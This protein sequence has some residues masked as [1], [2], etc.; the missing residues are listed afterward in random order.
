M[1]QAKLIHKNIHMWNSGS[2]GKHIGQES[3]GSFERESF[4]LFLILS[5]F[6]RQKDC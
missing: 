2:K 1:A 6:L 3:V 4:G 5:H